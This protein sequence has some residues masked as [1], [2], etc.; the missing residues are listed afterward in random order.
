MGPY[1]K[2]MIA[3]AMVGLVLAG[4]NAVR[5]PD[6][7]SREFGGEVAGYQALAAMTNCDDLE[8]EFDRGQNNFE[9]TGERMWEGHREAAS[10]RLD[11]LKCDVN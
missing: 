11:E 7:Y 9:D 6:E 3:L 10:Q 4:C 1:R 5:T 8:Q 2:P